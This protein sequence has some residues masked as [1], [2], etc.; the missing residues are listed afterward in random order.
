MEVDK[1]GM[2]TLVQPLGRLLAA[3]NDGSTLWLFDEEV[4]REGTQVDRVY[5]Y[6]RWLNGRSVV[7]TARCR[8]TGSG[9][10]SSG[11]RFDVLNP[12]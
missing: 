4:P 9:E 10:R 12:G 2:P 8:E 11:L 7:W 3:D 1:G 6:M 5:R